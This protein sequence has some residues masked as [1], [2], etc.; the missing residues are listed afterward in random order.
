M[1]AAG[2]AELEILTTGNFEWYDAPTDGQLISKN[3]SLMPNIV[4]SKTYYVQDASSI[5]ITTGPKA[6]TFTGGV[7]WGNIG[8]KFSAKTSFT[9][10]EITVKPFAIYNTDPVSIT[11]KLTQ[12]GVLLGTYTSEK[13]ANSGVTNYVLKFSTPIEI[14]GAG[15]Y[16]LEPTAGLAP[17]FL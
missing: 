6:T 3:L 14:P 5:A 15:S 10:T 4:S 13:T 17:L 1:C 8:A 16:I 9:I 2:Q 7:N 11:L 12:N